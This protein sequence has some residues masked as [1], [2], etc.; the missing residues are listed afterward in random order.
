[1]R[2]ILLFATA[3]ICSTSLYAQTVATF[4]AL[5]LA[6]ADTFYVNYTA[7]GTDVG[8]NNGLAHFPCMYDTAYGGLWSNGF[9]YSSRRDS[10]TSGYT[11]MYGAKAYTGYNGSDKYVVAN[12][13]GNKVFLLPAAQGKSVSGF[14]V[15]NS[16]YAYNSMRDGD[17]FA[18]KFG[19]ATGNDADWFKLTVFGYLNG[20]KK[21]DSVTFYLADFRDTNNATDYIVK[22]WRWVNLLPLGHVDSLQ[23]KLSSTD[24]GQ[25]G[26]NTPAYFCM[27]NF[28]TNETSVAVP[29][30]NTVAAKVYPNPATDKLYIE[31]AANSIQQVTVYG[32]DGRMIFTQP[33]TE[34]KVTLNTVS[35]VPGAYL[36][37]LNGADVHATVRFVK[38]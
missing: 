31:A 17:F 13:S 29:Q 14:Y 36:L 2:K 30:T 27:D 32:L 22:D 35:L 9:A 28:T 21:A 38:Q 15:T 18:K 24:N 19:G 1:M 12:G 16:T 23:F 25:Y 26:M 10:S 33:V 20:A 6:A 11:N 37:Q 3:A 7:P 4:D 8:F 5:S 34:E